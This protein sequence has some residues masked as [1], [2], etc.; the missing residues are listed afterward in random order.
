MTGWRA[1]AI[2]SPRQVA[3]LPRHPAGLSPPRV[4][5]RHFS[6]G[7]LGVKVRPAVRMDS[8][9]LLPLDWRSSSPDAIFPTPSDLE[10]ALLE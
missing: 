4:A 7:F 6:A 5:A 2:F 3:D 8:A 1:A 10:A 9:L